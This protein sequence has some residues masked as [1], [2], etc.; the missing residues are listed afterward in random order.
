MAR[1]ES[2][3]FE[4]VLLRN[5][6]NI[7]KEF[8]KSKRLWDGNNPKFRV[9]IWNTDYVGRGNRRPN[10]TVDSFSHLEIPIV[11]YVMIQCLDST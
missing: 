8:R 11:Q 1:S 9:G 4:L 7:S 2:L 6:W 3:F 10:N 5:R